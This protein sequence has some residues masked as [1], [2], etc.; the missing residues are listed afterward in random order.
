[1]DVFASGPS[2]GILPYCYAHRSLSLLSYA[3][4]NPTASCC[5]DTDH[6]EGGEGDVRDDDENDDNGYD[7][8]NDND[9]SNDDELSKTRIKKASFS[10]DFNYY[11]P[12]KH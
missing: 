8:D 1:M 12:R 5:N 11:V 6:D 10:I 2:G 9:D 7:G 3:A 4:T